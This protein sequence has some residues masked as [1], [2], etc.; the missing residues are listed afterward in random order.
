MS[1]KQSR[2]VM[3]DLSSCCRRAVATDCCGGSELRGGLR[4]DGA[5]LNLAK[6]Q[7]LAEHVLFYLPNFRTVFLSTNMKSLASWRNSHKQAQCR[8]PACILVAEVGLFPLRSTKQ[9]PD[10][11]ELG[12]FALARAF[13]GPNSLSARDCSLHEFLHHCDHEKMGEIGWLVC[14][15]VAWPGLG[16]VR[17]VQQLS[18]RHF[19]FTLS[20]VVANLVNAWHFE[21]GVLLCAWRVGY[22]FGLPGLFGFDVLNA[23]VPCGCIHHT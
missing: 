2:N 21:R 3:R 5:D 12:G 17:S 14:H 16:L 13:R 7:T 6:N 19:L 9:T 18:L 20:V 23:A 10:L 15:E 22:F 4:A 11:P 8:V 1:V